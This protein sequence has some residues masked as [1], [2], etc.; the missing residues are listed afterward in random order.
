[1]KPA[2]DLN[3]PLPWVNKLLGKTFEVN[4]YLIYLWFILRQKVVDK[5]DQK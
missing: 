1:M 4:S 2:G 5:L 3:T